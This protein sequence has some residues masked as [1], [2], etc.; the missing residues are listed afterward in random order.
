MKPTPLYDSFGQLYLVHE[1]MWSVISEVFGENEV[2][3]GRT[4]C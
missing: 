1:D 2:K 3:L 4:S